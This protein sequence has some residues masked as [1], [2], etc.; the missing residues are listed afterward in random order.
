MVLENKTLSY[1]SERISSDGYYHIPSTV[2]LNSSNFDSLKN[3]QASYF[4]LDPDDGGENR[5]R[6]Y[7]RLVLIKSACFETDTQGYIQSPEYNHTDGGKVRV[8]SPLERE[9][10]QSS[11]LRHIV[12]IDVDIA[13]KSGVI[14]FSG[15]V[16]IGIHQVRYQP[17]FGEVSRSS[18][19]GPHR[20]DEPIVFIHLINESH[21]L[22]G[23]ENT[24]GKDIDSFDS[25]IKLKHPLDTLCVTQKQFHSVTQHSLCSGE[26]GYRDILLLTFE[27]ETQLP[28]AHKELFVI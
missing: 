12:E 28:V 3:F 18:P 16:R 4:R 27:V 7:K 8:F 25:I 5:F 6:S 11:F 15:A 17:M 9:I 24:I 21:N 23:G 2:Y 20:D 19:V 13:R 10:V 1:I 14:S 22:I 26:I